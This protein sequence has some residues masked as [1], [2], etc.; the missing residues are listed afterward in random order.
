MRRTQ[1]VIPLAITLLGM[2]SAPLAAQEKPAGLIGELMADLEDV[3]GKL[4]G[5]AEAIPADKYGWK[6][7]EGVRATSEVFMH[8]AADNY[9]IPA[10]A[11]IAAPANTGVTAE[12]STAVAFEGRKLERE[13]TI[14]ELKSSLEHLK[15]AIAATKDADLEREVQFFGQP[16]TMRKV[17]I[18]A[19]GHLHEHLG[20]MIAYARGS[21]IVPPWSR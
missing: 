1:R 11:G 16:A 5:L 17:W 19:T 10:A 8:I 18:L 20:Q 21:G 12:Y 6:P 13:A 4:V 7:A 3:S 15:K 2:A 14:A 9:L